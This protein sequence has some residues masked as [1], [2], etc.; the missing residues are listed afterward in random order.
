MFLPHIPVVPYCLL[1]I[2]V[3]HSSPQP[4]TVSLVVAIGH[5][6][7]HSANNHIILTGMRM[8]PEL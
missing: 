7:S 5:F 1:C 2:E 4:G 8:S 6:L 3:V